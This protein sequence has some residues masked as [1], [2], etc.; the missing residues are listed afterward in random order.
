ME[1]CPLRALLYGTDA[2]YMFQLVNGAWFLL[3]E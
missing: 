3:S 2:D 1:E